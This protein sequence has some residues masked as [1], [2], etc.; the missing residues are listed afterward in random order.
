MSQSTSVAVVARAAPAQQTPVATTARTSLAA[1]LFGGS[2]KPEQ[3]VAVTKRVATQSELVEYRATIAAAEQR[4]L[5]ELNDRLAEPHRNMA[6]ATFQRFASP[7]AVA[8]VEQSGL[9]HS[10]HLHDV[11]ARAG[12][13]LAAKD[14]EI[15][16]LKQ[17][18]AHLR[19][20]GRR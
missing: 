18:V 6:I 12:Y 15:A 8:F 19:G 13:A 10:L 11:M 9:R 20:T 1:K 14:T 17:L 2:S 7:A 3:P 16:D 5:A 4:D